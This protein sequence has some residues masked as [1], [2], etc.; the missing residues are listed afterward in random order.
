MTTRAKFAEFKERFMKWDKEKP[1]DGIAEYATGPDFVL[2]F[3]IQDR[4]LQQ[5]VVVRISTTVN[6]AL[7]LRLLNDRIIQLY[8]WW[9]WYKTAVFKLRKKSSFS[10]A[11]PDHNS[12]ILF[13]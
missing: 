4:R 13:K 6:S 7:K 12:I 10:L 5:K 9:R 1:V 3:K 2:I 8:R 11:A